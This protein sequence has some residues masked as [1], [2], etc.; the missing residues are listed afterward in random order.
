MDE[1]S[2]QLL[3]EVRE[4]LLSQPEAVA[5]QDGE[6][7]RERV[8]NLFLACEPLTNWRSVQVTARRIRN[9]WATFVRE[10]VE[11]HVWPSEPELHVSGTLARFTELVQGF[12]SHFT[13]NVVE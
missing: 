7:H 2:K 13:G 3:T 11:V 6:Y 1:I 4:P 10:L 8:R 5:K 9:D 12:Q